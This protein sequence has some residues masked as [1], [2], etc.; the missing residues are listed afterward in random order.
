MMMTLNLDGRAI[1][2]RPAL[3][4]AFAEAL[5]FPP[6]YGRNLDALFDCLTEIHQPCA[7]EITHWRSLSTQLGNYADRLMALLSRIC[8]ENPH[9]RLQIFSDAP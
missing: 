7:I 4:D 2:S 1:D 9:I 8:R 6:Y 5:G 3:H